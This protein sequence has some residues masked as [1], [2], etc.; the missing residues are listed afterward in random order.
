MGVQPFSYTADQAAAI[1]RALDPEALLSNA[2][3][4]RYL[5]R[6][7]VIV[8]AAVSQAAAD[9]LPY[10]NPAGRQLKKLVKALDAVV[11]A[12]ETVPVEL[13]QR[14][15]AQV[16]VAMMLKPLL[17]ESLLP[18]DRGAAERLLKSDRF[19]LMVDIV[20]GAADLAAEPLCQAGKP[21]TVSDDA[22]AQLPP[23]VADI[24]RDKTAAARHADPV[25]PATGA[26]KNHAVRWAVRSLGVLYMEVTNDITKAQ[27]CV[28]SEDGFDGGFY[29]FAKAALAPVMR[30]LNLRGDK[31]LGAAIVQ[32]NHEFR[33]TLDRLTLG[34]K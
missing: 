34:K 1:F 33:E 4:D 31:A 13:R 3:R 26:P 19:Q 24:I 9:P 22:L 14:V 16:D 32:A 12:Y 8:R 10:A 23:D 18:E 11:K 25:L 17:M 21:I 30:Q 29:W 6:I 7:T 27:S 5:I 15:F 2:E 20:R 28:Y